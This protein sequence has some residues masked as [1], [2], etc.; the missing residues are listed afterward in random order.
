MTHKP[1]KSHFPTS[2]AQ[3]K[4]LSEA[5]CINWAAVARRC[6][7]SQSALSRTLHGHRASPR[8]RAIVDRALGISLERLWTGFPDE[9]KRVNWSAVARREGVSQSAL[10]R[11]LHGHRASPRM[12]AIVAQALGVTPE[13]IWPARHGRS[14]GR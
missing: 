8:M 14:G 4:A 13:S 2:T 7:V 6:G 12:R 5:A 3:A 1:I 10:S 9:E 11:T